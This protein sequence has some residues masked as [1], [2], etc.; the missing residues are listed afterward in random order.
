M[1]THSTLGV[2]FIE[3]GF[4]ARTPRSRRSSRSCPARA[5]PREGGRLR[6]DPPAR[7]RADDD[8]ALQALVDCSRRSC[9]IVGKTWALH[10]EKVTR[11]DPEENLAMIARL[12]RLLRAQG[13]R[14]IYDAE[15]FFDGYR[16]NPDYALRSSRRGRSRRR[17][18]R[19]ATPTAAPARRGG[20][21][22][23]ATWWPSSAMRRGRHPHPQRRGLR[24]GQLA[25]GRRRRRAAVQGTI[26]GFG[27]RCGNADLVTILANLQL[28]LGYDVRAAT[29]SSAA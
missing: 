1:P 6:H 23:R 26:N 10:L 18:V 14:V 4:P 21:G 15:H 2:D 13:K 24:R 17:D 5:Q 22:H 8:P 25:R 19:S 12:G 3:A 29:S 16:D 28:K 7:R 20:R 9:T 27:E 11:V